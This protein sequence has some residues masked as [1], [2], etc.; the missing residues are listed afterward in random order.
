MTRFKE[1]KEPCGSVKGFL[2]WQPFMMDKGDS[3]TTEY[4][5]ISRR[6]ACADFRDDGYVLTGT[7]RRD[8]RR[9]LLQ[10]KLIKMEI[11]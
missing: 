11:G 5:F 9:I 2:G 7:V 10:V 4:L 3:V 8:F 6:R 1:E